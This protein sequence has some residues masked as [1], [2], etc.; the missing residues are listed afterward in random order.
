MRHAGLG[1]A[2]SEQPLP[3][4]ADRRPPPSRAGLSAPR[5]GLRPTLAAAL[6]ALPLLAVLAPSAQAQTTTLSAGAVEGSDVNQ[7]SEV[8]TPAA[9]FV[10]VTPLAASVSLRNCFTSSLSTPSFVVDRGRTNLTLDGSGCVDLTGDGSS[11]TQFSFSVYGT[12]DTTDEPDEL[13]TLTISEDPD[14]LLPTGFSIDSNANSAFVTIRDDD[15]TLVELARAGTGAVREGGTVEFTVTL[16]RDLVAGEAI[17]VPLSIGGTDVD[18]DD[19]SLA[20]K[21]GAGLNTGVALSGETTATPQ[22]AFSG[23]AARTATLTLTALLDDDAGAETL[24]VALGPDDATANGFDRDGLATNVGGGADPSPTANRFEVTVNDPPAPAAPAGFA[25]AA[26]DSEA[27]LSWTDPSNAAIDGYQFRQRTPPTTGRW[28]SWTAIASSTATTT[29]HTV[30]GLT[31]GTAYG[32]EV[33]AVSGGVAGADSSEAT[34]TPTAA[35]AGVT[36]AQPTDRQVTEGSTTDTATFTVALSTRPSDTVAVTVTAPAGLEL[37]GPGGSTFSGSA[38]LAF[39]AST[40]NAA[41][42]V[43][44]RATDD[45]TDSPLGREL[46]VTYRTSSRD[47]SY[48]SL[49][50]TAATVTVVDNDPTTVTLAGAAGDVAEGATKTFTVILGRGLVNG[51]TLAVPLTFGGAATRGTDYTTACPTTLPTGVT[52]ANLDSGNAAVTFTG[53]STGTTATQ[54]TL[55]LTAATDSTAET[56]GE[57]VDIDLGTLNANSGTGLE[58]GASGTDNLADFSITD[59]ST[60]AF[61][62]GSTAVTVAEGDDDEVVLTL[63][64]S[65]ARSA[66][67]AVR[68]IAVGTTASQHADF[69]G[70]PYTVNFPAGDTTAPLTIAIVDDNVPE[71]S[72]AFG[73]TIVALGLPAGVSVG[74]PSE[75]T[76]TI[77]DDDQPHPAPTGLTATAGAGSVALAWRYTPPAPPAVDRTADFQY[78]QGT[79]TTVVWG[80]W[81]TIPGSDADTRSHTVRGLTG[82]TEYAFEVRARSR[83]GG[84]FRSGQSSATVRATPLAGLADN[85]RAWAAESG[86]GT[87]CA[88]RWKRVLKALGQTDADLEMLT[89]LSYGEAVVLTV[90]D[91][92]QR[93]RWETVAAELGAREAKRVVLTIAAAPPGP[94]TEGATVTF[95]LTA[96]VAPSVSLVGL[97]VQITEASGSDFLAAEDEGLRRLPLNAGETSAT[98]ASRLSMTTQTSPTGCSRQGYWHC[99]R[100]IR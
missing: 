33:R 3:Y 79:G 93:T 89:P 74:T 57:T 47:R 26:G 87:A 31:N 83:P 23:G 76:V 9:L 25:A 28:G 34:A 94:L 14:N 16:G 41:Q 45:S 90:T 70:G 72:E 97:F 71:E 81:T 52:C 48:H 65:A 62:S 19:W 84:G 53:P 8:A 73:V 91:S 11:T 35:T 66:A 86:C 37:A 95:T 36:T 50:G 24:V 12:A 38:S 51:E 4:H 99:R 80:A 10:T 64:L 54:V 20:L 40:W 44:M 42:T 85:V 55:T 7:E 43:T 98:L 88:M 56:G 2:S 39:T 78:R 61:A 1:P 60:V 29:T 75:A 100:S 63:T 69:T 49:S 17:D 82:T 92:A 67:T 27:V 58:G 13:V 59:G 5:R 30:T 6:L 15:P 96:A 22:L 18:T 21:T 32:F 46:S 77:R 68:L